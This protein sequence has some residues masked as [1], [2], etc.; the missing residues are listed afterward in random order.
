VN[1]LI[2]G[3]TG[4]VSSRFVMGLPVVHQVKSLGR[5]KVFYKSKSGW[6]DNSKKPKT[7]RCL[8]R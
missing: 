5:D 2:F 3:A 8:N 4:Y 6:I 1:I 7:T